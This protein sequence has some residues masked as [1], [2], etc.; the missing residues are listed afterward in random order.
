MNRIVTIDIDHIGIIC[1]DLPKLGKIFTELG[2]A[3]GGS[4]QMD[5]GI[6]GEAAPTNL[7]FMFDN[8]YIECIQSNKGDYLQEYLH[9]EAALHTVVLS[10]GNYLQSHRNTIAAGFH[11]SEAMVASRPANHGT[12]K[13]MASFGWFK[14]LD[15]VIPHTLLGVAEHL[16]RDLIFQ[17]QRHQHPNSCFCVDQ[18]MVACDQS[19]A[20]LAQPTLEML[21]HSLVPSSYSSGIRVLR[22]MDAAEINNVFGVLVDPS[23][24]HYVGL[25]FGLRQPECLVPLL[26]QGGYKY[27]RSSEGLLVD[28]TQE[29]GLFFL[30]A[31]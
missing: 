7:H 28:L 11:P 17:P 25:R 30:F 4:T 20:N 26:Q 1:T 3:T 19:L 18:L 29:M 9:S 13:G 5:T 16:T 2:F 31:T 22:I 21:Y 10:T 15:C 12:N 6:A 8:T 27:K 23:R 14:L 24:S